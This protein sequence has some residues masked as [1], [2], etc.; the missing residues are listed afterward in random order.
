MSYQ[1]FCTQV[2]S[3][4]KEL[5]EEY[6]KMTLEEFLDFRQEVMKTV[7]VKKELSKKF[8]TAVFDMIQKNLFRQEVT[9]KSKTA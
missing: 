1:E 2:A 6:R 7:T 9:E 4:V 5:E 3:M 8:M